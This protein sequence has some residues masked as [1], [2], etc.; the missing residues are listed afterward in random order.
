[1][2]ETEI[3]KGSVEYLYVD[4]TGDVVLDSQPVRLAFATTLT[5]S[6]TW[7]DATWMG[8]AGTSRSCRYLL[9][10]LLAVGKVNIFVKITDSPEIPIIKAGTL[11][12]KA[13]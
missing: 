12:V 9:D 2:T 6:S 5:S 7:V 3:V 11:R 13:N 4:V 10:G 1:M 8:S